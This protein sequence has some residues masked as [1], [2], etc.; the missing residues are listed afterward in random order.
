Y[1]WTKISGPAQF[2]IVSPTQAQT[3]IDSLSKGVYQFELKATDTLGAEGMDTVMVTVNAAPNQLPSAN[4]GPDK[5]INLPTD[6]VTL[7]GDGT[8]A[9]GTI[10]SYQW[11]KISGP[12]QFFIVSLTQPQTVINN[13]VQG[14]YQFE[15]I[16][17]DNLGAIGRDTVI[18]TVNAGP[19]QSPLANAGL[20]IN[21]SLPTNSVN[22]I[23][24][25]TD[26][27]GTITSYLWT[28]ISGPSQFI[29][30]SPAEAQTT[31]SNLVQGIYQFEFK[32]TDNNGAI[33]KD[34][35]VVAV[36][37]TGIYQTPINQPPIANA[38]I[39][40]NMTLPTNFV[41]LIGNGTDADGTISY[42]E[43]SKI[44]GPS[45]YAIRSPNN[46]QT[47]IY[48]LSQGI[49][50]F[51]LS[52]TD[53]LGA[54]GTDTVTVTVNGAAKNH[55]VVPNSNIDQTFIIPTSN[56]VYPNPA[57][58]FVNIKIDVSI[59][60]N[61]ANTRINDLNGRLQ[62]IKI[63]NSVGILVYHEQLPVTQQTTI[64]HITIKNYPAG[65]YFINIGPDLKFNKQ[66][67]FIKQ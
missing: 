42:Y 55:A 43:W 31:I 2:N 45:L 20:D 17:T 10:T 65:I 5:T 41:T 49:Y 40:I 3:M 22:L 38:G 18:V 21:L 30:V 15:L 66:L 59:S 11:T 9:D 47:L 44:S 37:G 26:F 19:N 12:D 57:M 51:E 64:K 33:G 36:N 62:N 67:K 14:V 27:D 56:I 35:V 50:E 63:Y 29:I 24:T 46:S 1:Q 7:T 48:N 54:V 52:V 8:D 53:N 13:L 39:D 61:L 6:L 34:T 23:G 4:A 32:I 58:E 28:K 16:V 25:G 60:D